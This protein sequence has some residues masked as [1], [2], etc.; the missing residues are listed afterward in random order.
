MEMGTGKKE[1]HPMG[2]Q[3]LCRDVRG[4]H[5]GCKTGA[6]SLAIVGWVTEYPIVDISDRFYLIVID[7]MI[8]LLN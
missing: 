3:G 2:V 1:A 7:T 4:A 6:S 5:G 8:V